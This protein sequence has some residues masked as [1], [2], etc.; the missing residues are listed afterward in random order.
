VGTILNLHKSSEEAKAECAVRMRRVICIGIG[1]VAVIMTTTVAMTL[2]MIV[3]TD[4]PLI[5]AIAIPSRQRRCEYDHG[6][7]H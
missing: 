2:A 7:T 1:I 3:T 4:R 6:Q 5:I